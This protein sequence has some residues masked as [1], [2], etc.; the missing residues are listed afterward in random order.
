MRRTIPILVLALACALP[1]A[2][3]AHR[4]DAPPHLSC[5]EIDGAFS[6]FPGG[7]QT[8]VL[9]TSVDGVPQP[10]HTITADGP[11]FTT[12][13][14]FWNPDGGSHVVRAWFSWTTS[15]G[16]HGRGPLQTT[17]ITNCPPPPA[18]VTVVQQ[19]TSSSQQG[20]TTTPPQGGAPS[21]SGGG[22]AGDLSEYVCTSHRIYR[23][24]VRPSLRGQRVV[25][26]ER[27][28]VRGVERYGSF[29]RVTVRGQTRF[30]VTADYR[31]LT[32]PRGQLR[33]VTTVLEL[34]DGRKVRTVQKLRLCL[35]RDGNPNDTPTQERADQ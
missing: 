17:T 27:V 6:G 18:P 26:I 23:F 31:D 7:P 11:D 32:V 10:D 1:A 13:T 33:T 35:D 22:V 5:A 25:G 21:T 29:A 16:E 20:S 9:H 34:A 2:A 14:G 8:V 30:R 28:L 12:S 15:T 24:L 3:Q 4:S 19:T